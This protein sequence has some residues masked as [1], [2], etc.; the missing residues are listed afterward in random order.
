MYSTIAEVLVYFKGLAAWAATWCVGTIMYQWIYGLKRVDSWA[1]MP[2]CCSAGVH[3]GPLH[4]YVWLDKLCA[5][6]LG[7][8]EARRQCHMHSYGGG[9]E[10]L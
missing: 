5:W 7:W 6:W 8:H 10:R 4:V 9:V 1:E 3:G 2:P